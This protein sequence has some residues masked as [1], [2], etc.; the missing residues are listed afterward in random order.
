MFIFTQKFYK[1]MKDN[2]Q[3]IKMG[4]T[5]EFIDQAYDALNKQMMKLDSSVDNYLKNIV[6]PHFDYS[7]NSVCEKDSRDINAQDRELLLKTIKEATAENIL[8]THGT[9]T[10]VETAEFLDKQPV[11]D[12]KIII[13]GS[14][15]P[16]VGFSASDAPFNLGYSLASFKNIEAGVYIC[17][18]GGLFKYNEVK[19][20]TELL[21][22]E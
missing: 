5:I 20:N 9:F 14:M 17:M 10:M 22:F 6:K 13:T 3:I 7:V 19:K 1:T 2:I 12:K 11:A 15:V 8:I 21:R 18:N 16:V 4:G